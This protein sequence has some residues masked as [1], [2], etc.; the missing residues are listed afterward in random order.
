MSSKVLRELAQTEQDSTIVR[1][2]AEVAALRCG[3]RGLVCKQ[4]PLDRPAVSVVS[5]DINLAIELN[6]LAKEMGFHLIFP[7]PEISDLFVFPAKV[8]IVNRRA[9]GITAWH[10]F[11]EF[12]EEAN[13]PLSEDAKKEL[14]AGGIDFDD[15]EI[16]N[17]PLI[18][19]DGFSPEEEEAWGM[20]LPIS[21]EVY[22]AEE[23]MRDWIVAKVCTLVQGK[24]R[25]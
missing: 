20:L 8:R 13:R 4:V 10:Y 2:T 11:L 5:A 24:K 6:R 3:Q 21:M 15:F 25:E 23:W 9:L 18:L 1:E 12:Q 16:A 7:E 17:S 19:I 22:R 14:V